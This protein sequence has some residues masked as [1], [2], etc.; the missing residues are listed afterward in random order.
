MSNGYAHECYTAPLLGEGM[1][2]WLVFGSLFLGFALEVEVRP[3]SHL[4]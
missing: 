4:N 3:E 1:D 2:E